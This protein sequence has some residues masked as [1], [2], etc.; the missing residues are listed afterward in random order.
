MELI[1]KRDIDTLTNTGIRSRQLIFPENSKSMRVTITRVTLPAGAKNPPHR[2]A[3][4]EQV[5][6]ALHGNG[7]LLLE[8]DGREAFAAG[9]V[10]RVEDNEFH[11]LENAGDMEFEYISITSPP[12]NF[13]GAY[14]SMW[15]AS[16]GE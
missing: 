15:S 4:S 7:F 13:R 5:W 10:V 6:V 2:H 16:S 8:N 12:I 14:E 11:G 3:T 1:R 9:D